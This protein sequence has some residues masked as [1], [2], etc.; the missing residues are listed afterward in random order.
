MPQVKFDPTINLGHILTAGTFLVAVFAAYTS[1]RETDVEHQTRIE[2]IEKGD[3]RD[4][5]LQRQILDSLTTIREDIAGLK[6][7][8]PLPE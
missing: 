5:I 6:A 8:H 1:L 4:L 3:D 2:A 7:V